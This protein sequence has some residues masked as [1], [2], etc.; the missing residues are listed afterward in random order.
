MG[1]QTQGQEGGGGNEW[2]TPFSSCMM[3]GEGPPLEGGIPSAA[4]HMLNSRIENYSDDEDFF[5]GRIDL[6][7]Q[8][9]EDP[10]DIENKDNGEDLNLPILHGESDDDFKDSSDDDETIRGEVNQ[11]TIKQQ[12]RE[13]TWDDEFSTYSPTPMEFV[14]FRGQRYHGISFH[15]F[16][17]YSIYFGPRFYY[18]E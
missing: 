6:D 5:N 17:N 18:R 4:R 11:E 14:G 3:E 9:Y 13:T 12:Y 8:D 7:V 10:N 16:Y 15:H 2:I 1:T